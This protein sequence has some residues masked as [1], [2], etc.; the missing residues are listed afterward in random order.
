MIVSLPELQCPH[1]GFK[2]LNQVGAVPRWTRVSVLV[3]QVLPVI[4]C[5][6]LYMATVAI[7]L[8]RRSCR[9]PRRWQPP[10]LGSCPCRQG[11]NARRL[12]GSRRLF[13]MGPH[14]APTDHSSHDR[15]LSPGTIV[16]RPLC[17]GRCSPSQT[18]SLNFAWERLVAAV[19]WGAPSSHQHIVQADRVEALMTVNEHRHG[20]SSVH[21]CNAQ[22]PRDN[23]Q[24]GV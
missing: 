18:C 7:P 13:P 14:L 11:C 8:C 2:V 4:V 17:Q 20:L 6:L 16:E 23:N 21:S 5:R 10:C 3:C 9:W 1:V 19:C 22:W 15:N 12:H 24:V